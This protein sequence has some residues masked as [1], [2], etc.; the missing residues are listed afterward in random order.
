M[1]NLEGK[2][3]YRTNHALLYIQVM[4]D[5]SVI[6]LVNLCVHSL[7]MK[8]DSSCLFLAFLRLFTICKPCASD[9]RH[10]LASFFHLFFRVFAIV[11]YL[12]CDWISKN[13]APCF[14]LIITLL[15]FD[16]WSVKVRGQL[17][18]PLT[19]QHPGPCFL[20]PLISLTPIF[21]H[22]TK[23]TFVL[24]LF[25]NVTGRLLVG[26]RWWN[27]IDDDGKSLWVFEAKKVR[28]LS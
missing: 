11:S 18:I 10:P 25:Q 20:G 27:Q 28:S 26:L 12:L 3:L 1:C 22:S 4:I 23:L 13:F 7:Y 6:S 19:F 14:V 17:W 21:F 9:F 24:F 15:S 8:V 2:K 16:F 5:F